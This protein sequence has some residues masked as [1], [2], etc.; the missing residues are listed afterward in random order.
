PD[1]VTCDA[2]P[3]DSPVPDAEMADAA[4]PDAATCDAAPA[5]SPVTDAEMADAA[6]PDSSTPDA[7]NADRAIADAGQR[8][9][10]LPPGL[11]WIPIP[12]GVYEMG[13]SP[14][15]T[16]CESDE[17]PRHTVAISAFEMTAT[18][19]TQAQYQA[20]VGSNP[21]SN[22][23]CPTCPVETIRW[24]QARN[25]CAAIGGRLPSEA[26]WEYA[27][28]AGTTTRYYCGDNAACLGGIAWYY[29][30]SDTGGGHATQPV[31]GKTA[32]DFGLYDMLG[33]VWEWNEDC[34]HIDYN[35]AP[36]T[37]VVWTGGA[38]EHCEY[39]MVRGGSYHPDDDDLRVSY[40]GI[41]D[42][43]NPDETIGARCAR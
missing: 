32:N 40:R 35:G 31:A 22:T 16:S 5:D 38:N 2:A 27:A 7:A 4:L 41:F 13:C 9:A 42:P 25:F 15:D 33:N 36:A 23:G 26:E 3:A 14:G 39:R 8:D 34:W 28:R 29:D 30:N 37:G 24:Q 12:G 18:E 21:S 11:T 43:S 19:I 20:V 1:A 17:I 10:W 6:R